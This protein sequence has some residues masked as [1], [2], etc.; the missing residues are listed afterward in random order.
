MLFRSIPHARVDFVEIDPKFCKQIKINCAH[1][2]I[3]ARRYRIIRS[4]MFGSIYPAR[5]QAPRASAASNGYD[6]IFANPPYCAESKPE[7]VQKSVKNFEPHQAV[8]GGGDGLVFIRRFLSSA[9]KYIKK[10]GMIY[11]EFDPSQKYAIARMAKDYA[12]KNCE[13]FKDQYGRW[14]YAILTQ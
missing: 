3:S 4:N 6:Y 9:R 5:V 13:F 2:K 1:N 10:G 7:R 12:Y 14:R 11:M 8:F